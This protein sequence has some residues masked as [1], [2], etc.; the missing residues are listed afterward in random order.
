M[1]K[2]MNNSSFALK[3]QEQEETLPICRSIFLSSL[4]RTHLI[5]IPVAAFSQ[6]TDQ[7]EQTTARIAQ[8]CPSTSVPREE[9]LSIVKSTIATN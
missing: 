5:S 3:R 9:K 8:I 1:V 7:R 4:R 6:G 2:H